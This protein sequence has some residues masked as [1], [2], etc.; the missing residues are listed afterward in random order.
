MLI[1][2]LIYASHHDDTPI[3][4]LDQILRKSRANNV[5]DGISGALVIAKGH[6]L[7]LLEGDRQA[8]AQC[9]MR[10]AQDRRH[11]DVSL[12]SAADTD[13]RLF[14]EWS[15]HR[16]EASRIKQEILSCYTINGVFDPVSMSQAAIEDMC[17]TLSVGHWD[18]L[19]A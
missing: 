2:R 4:I 18:A 15:M 7:Q 13:F 14:H 1:T 9:F 12:I 10:I 8:V 6:F 3:E 16:I 17:R 5:R 19:A 11:R